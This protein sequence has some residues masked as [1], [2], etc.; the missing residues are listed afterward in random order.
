MDNAIDGKNHSPFLRHQQGGRQ[1]TKGL[2][3]HKT[4][5][6]HFILLESSHTRMSNIVYVTVC[7]LEHFGV[8]NGGGGGDV[9]NIPSRILLVY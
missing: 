6:Q 5:I 8:C 7:R 9:E 3:I 2:H 1:D 4:F